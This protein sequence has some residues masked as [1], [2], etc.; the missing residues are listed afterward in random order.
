MGNDFQWSSLLP[1]GSIGFFKAHRLVALPVLQTLPLEE[2]LPPPVRE[3]I[4]QFVAARQLAGL[5]VVLSRVD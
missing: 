1:R 3:S 2:P 4:G 5:P